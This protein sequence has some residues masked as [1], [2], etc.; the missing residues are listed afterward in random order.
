MPTLQRR[1]NAQWE[2]YEYRD[3]GSQQ[4][5]QTESLGYEQSE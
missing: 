1:P 2:H 4:L 5:P 3:L